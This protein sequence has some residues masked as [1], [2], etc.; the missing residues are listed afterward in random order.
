[1]AAL[2]APYDSGSLEKAGPETRQR[3][4]EVLARGVRRSGLKGRKEGDR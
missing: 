2:R 1:M 3:A 4:T